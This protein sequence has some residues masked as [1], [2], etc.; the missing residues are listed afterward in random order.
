MVDKEKY[1][2]K[3][4]WVDMIPKNSSNYERDFRLRMWID[5]DADFSSIQGENG[6]SIYPY[7]NKTFAITV[8]V[9]ADASMN[10]NR[11]AENV[12][13]KNSATDCVDLECVLN[14]LYE[15]LGGNHKIKKLES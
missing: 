11:Y 2:E 4:I 13:H 15:E 7:N 1:I 5:E 9:Y 8:N 6:G 14:E 10:Y 12:K 3:V